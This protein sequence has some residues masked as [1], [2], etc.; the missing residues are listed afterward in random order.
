MS[1]KDRLGAICATLPGAVEAHP[2]EGQL[3]SWKLADKMFACMGSKD[4]GVSVKTPSVETATML[5]DASVAQRAKYFHRS[6][7]RLPEDVAEEELRHRVQVSY[8][9]IRGSLSKK[10]QAGLAEREAI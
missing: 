10:M 2:S 3:H 1:F 6:W 5:I 4:P 8:D 7:V 9:L